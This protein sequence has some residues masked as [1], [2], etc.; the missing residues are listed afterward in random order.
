LKTGNI[1]VFKATYFYFNLFFT[2]KLIIMSTILGTLNTDVKNW[3]WFVVKGLLLI[4]AGV[5]VF[6]RPLEGYVGLSV[7]FSIVM[8]GAGL[9][10]IFFAT[11][12]SNVLKGW[13][14]T[15]ASGILDVVI[16]IYLL[17][18]P[19]VTMATLPIILG[20]WLLFRSFYLIGASFDLK[21]LGVTDW[22]WLLFGGILSSILGWFVLYNPGAGAISIIYVSGSAFIVA[23]VFYLYFSAKL[24]AM[25]KAVTAVKERLQHG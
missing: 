13:G 6:S 10:Q 23:G 11:S 22:G 8:L 21:S 24:K 1:R 25:N 7:L 17:A 12:N 15:L 18:F 19:T 2:L 16:A 3:W 20:F 14:W 9:A 4:I 5:A